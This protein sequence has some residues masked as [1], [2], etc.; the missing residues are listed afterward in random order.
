MLRKYATTALTVAFILVILALVAGQ[1]LGQPILLSYVTSG[2]MAPTISEGDGFVA[3]PDQLAGNIGEGDVVVF[4][5]QEIEGGGL[6]THRVVGETPEGYITRGDGNPFTD[7]DG[8]EPPVTDDQV[9]AVAWQPGGNVVTI[10]ALGTAILGIQGVALG[11]HTTVATALGFE[12]SG[13][14]QEVGFLLFVS[15]LILLLLTVLHGLAQRTGIERGRSRSRSR[16]VLLDPRYVALFL[17][18]IVVLPANVAMLVPSTTHSVQVEGVAFEETAQPG[19]EVDV[20][21]TTTNEGFVTMLVMF[22]DPLD[23]TLAERRLEVA[24]GSAV[25]TS[26]STAIPP[27][28]E[29]RTVAVSERRYV[30]LLPPSLLASLHDINPLLALTAINVVLALSILALVVG[31]IGLRQQRVRETNREIP[32]A[33]RLKRLLRG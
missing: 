4:Y 20:R 6:T 31:G 18:V 26:L 2:S 17:V 13:D 7:Q 10:P 15:G 14:A 27:P 29:Q 28:G 22:D 5:A 19:D 9:V 8:S 12:G 11:I 30:M 33:V 21:L 3:I 24:G 25:S 23:G 32:L 1:V 16:Q